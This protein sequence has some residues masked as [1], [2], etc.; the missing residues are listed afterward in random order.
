MSTEVKHESQSFI[1]DFD[2]GRIIQPISSIIRNFKKTQTLSKTIVNP[3]SYLNTLQHIT[4]GQFLFPIFHPQSIVKDEPVLDGFSSNEKTIPFNFSTNNMA[5]MLQQTKRSIGSNLDG[6]M[7]N[8]QSITF[9]QLFQLF[10]QMLAYSYIAKNENIPV[11]LRVALQ[12]FGIFKK[13][14]G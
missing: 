4:N 8:N 6:M 13:L 1:A 12:Y 5:E 14:C 9:D 11:S 3:E 2:V 10:T 7:P